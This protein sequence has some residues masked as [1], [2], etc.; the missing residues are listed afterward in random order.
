MREGILTQEES[1]AFVKLGVDSSSARFLD[2][3]A[4]MEI[5]I[6]KAVTRARVLGFLAD[7]F[8]NAALRV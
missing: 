3:A 2:H 1:E 7:R 5:G 6:S 4:L 8:G